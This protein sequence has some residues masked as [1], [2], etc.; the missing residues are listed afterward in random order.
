VVS[1]AGDQRIIITCQHLATRADNGLSGLSIKRGS[2][3]NQEAPLN[4]LKSA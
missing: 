1:V 2:K 4:E 3:L